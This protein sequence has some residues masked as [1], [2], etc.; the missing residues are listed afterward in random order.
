MPRFKHLKWKGTTVDRLTGITFC[1]N[2]MKC[3]ASRCYSSCCSL[4]GSRNVDLRVAIRMALL[5]GTLFS[6]SCVSYSTSGSSLCNSFLE[7]FL[8]FELKCKRRNASTEMRPFEYKQVH[9]RFMSRFC[10]HFM[11]S[12]EGLK[13]R[14]RVSKMVS[15]PVKQPNWESQIEH[16]NAGALWL[17]LLWSQLSVHIHNLLLA[18]IQWIIFHHLRRIHGRV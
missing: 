6:S 14:V 4:C 10:D 7:R 12:F 5:C 15:I 17:V 16:L 1:C 13:L 18:V 11:L 8:E 9:I 3:E 2:P